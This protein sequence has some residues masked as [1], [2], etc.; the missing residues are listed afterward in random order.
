MGI[1]ELVAD[2][3]LLVALLIAVAAGL[4]SFASPCVLPLVPGYL[5]YIGGLAG[6][7]QVAASDS[8]QSQRLALRRERRRL[9]LGVS[10]FVAGFSLIFILFMVLASSVGIWLVQYQDLITRIMGVVVIVMGLVFV[11]LFRPLQQTKKLSLA[12]KVGLAGAPVLGAGFAVGWTPCLGP[13]L[14][15]ISSLSLQSGSLTRG[16]LLGLAYC[17]GLGIPFVLVAIGFGWVSTSTNFLRRHIRTI[18]IIGG[19]VLV[20]IGVLMVTGIWNQMMYSL[21]AVMNAYVT[22]L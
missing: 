18:N 13:T 3:Q 19:S 11:G 2:G 17:V 8:G 14:I 10:L 20:L 1:G 15:A 16:A 12:P 22:P 7:D 5:A 4:V 21:Q 6:T 9:V